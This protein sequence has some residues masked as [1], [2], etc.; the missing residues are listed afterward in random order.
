MPSAG[1]VTGVG[2]AVGIAGLAASVCEYGGGGWPLGSSHWVFP[3][4]VSILHKERWRACEYVDRA[5]F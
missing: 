4:A 1:L 2:T 3:E 5:L